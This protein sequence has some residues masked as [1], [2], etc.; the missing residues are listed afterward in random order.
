M[1]DTI[2]QLIN[3]GEN[4]NRIAEV[5]EVELELVLAVYAMGGALR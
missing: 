5:L 4:L 3:H 2:R 1:L